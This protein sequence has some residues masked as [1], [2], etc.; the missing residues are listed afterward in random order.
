T[1]A[2]TPP[3]TSRKERTVPPFWS[4]KV[5]LWFCQLE[6]Q[7]SIAGVRQDSTKF[8]YV[9]G[10]LDSRYIEEVENIICNPPAQNQYKTLKSELI[11]RLSDS[12][13]QRVRKL[14]ESEE[15]G[16]RTP[17]QFLRHLR[18]LAGK[19]VN[20]E[21]IK[22]LWM[23][24]LPTPTQR[25]LAASLQQP[26]ADMAEVADR[27]QEIG[28]SRSQVSQVNVK[29]DVPVSIQT[30]A[31]SKLATLREEMQQLRLALQ[32]IRAGKQQRRRW[33]R[34]RSRSRDQSNAYHAARTTVID[35]VPREFDF[36][37]T[38]YALR[39]FNY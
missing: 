37:D 38:E 34:P 24:R 6:A 27:V 22:T 19:N 29:E 26:L 18:K 2:T 36:A 15:L 25:V 28:P 1:I 20:E 32:E 9:V 23:N 16:D 17:S 8:G 21:F 4:Y 3:E 13:S 12:S 10:N 35:T 39:N 11:K 30:P 31:N 33:S 7:F 5:G 14:L